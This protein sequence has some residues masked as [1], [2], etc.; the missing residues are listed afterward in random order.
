[1][2]I[3]YVFNI[4]HDNETDFI[5]NLNKKHFVGYFRENPVK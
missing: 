2:S 1:M 5:N 4:K 3:S